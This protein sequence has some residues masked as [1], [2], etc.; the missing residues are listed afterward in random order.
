MKLENTT[1]LQPTLTLK[2]II[3]II[4]IITVSD[5]SRDEPGAPFMHFSLRGTWASMSK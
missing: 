5:A 4:Y 3:V 2:L 1:A